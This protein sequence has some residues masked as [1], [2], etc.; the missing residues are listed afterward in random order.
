MNLDLLGQLTFSDDIVMGKAY[1][2]NWLLGEKLLLLSQLETSHTRISL[3]CSAARTLSA[4]PEA[5]AAR[6]I[7]TYLLKCRSQTSLQCLVLKVHAD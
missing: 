7:K 5:S 4:A 1:R 6:G 3:I 2:G